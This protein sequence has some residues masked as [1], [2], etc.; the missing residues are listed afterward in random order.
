MI[1]GFVRRVS[2]QNIFSITMQTISGTLFPHCHDEGGG[3]RRG[4]VTPYM[5]SFTANYHLFW[6]RSIQPPDHR[7]AKGQ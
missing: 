7:K 3:T 6:I 4:Q 2:K 5:V 1:T